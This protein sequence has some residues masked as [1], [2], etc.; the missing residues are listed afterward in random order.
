MKAELVFCG[1]HCHFMVFGF[2]CK[3]FLKSGQRNED[4]TEY[5]N[6]LLQWN[7]KVYLLIINK[8]LTITQ[9]FTGH[10]KGYRQSQKLTRCPQKVYRQFGAERQT[11]KK[12]QFKNTF[13]KSQIHS[14]VNV[15]AHREKQWLTWVKTEISLSRGLKLTDEYEREES[16][17]SR[18]ICEGL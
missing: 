2:F 10:F 13:S 14:E 15:L 12:K 8:T 16:S 5:K 9:N 7:C 6:T 4:V 18:H 1:N 3:F 17:S 11:L